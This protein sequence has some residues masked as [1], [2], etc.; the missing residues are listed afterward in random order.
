[1]DRE[2]VKERSFFCVKYVGLSQTRNLGIDPSTSTTAFVGTDAT[3][4]PILQT[5]FLVTSVKEKLHRA[6]TLRDEVNL[7][8]LRVLRLR[9]FVHRNVR[10]CLLPQTQ[11][12]FV[13]G[14]E[15]AREPNRHLLP[16]KPSPAT[17]LARAIPITVT[18]LDLTSSSS[19]TLKHSR[20]SVM[21]G[22]RA[23]VGSEQPQPRPAD[24]GWDAV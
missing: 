7:H 14:G 6:F 2:C 11:K 16:S 8:H 9:G 22:I 10:V 18:Y 20:V 3:D 24:G 13:G 21:Y 5:S 23:Y 19:W 4:E 12:V 15:S 1:M 17:R